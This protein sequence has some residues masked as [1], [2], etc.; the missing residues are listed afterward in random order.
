MRFLFFPALWIQATFFAAWLLPASLLRAQTYDLQSGPTIAFFGDNAVQLGWQKPTGFIHLI[1]L[2][3]RQQ[4]QA[5]TV[6]PLGGGGN[7]SKDLL[8]RLG[9]D[10]LSKKPNFLVLNCGVSDV[11]RGPKNIPLDQYQASITAM[12]DQATAAG[13]KV[14][15]LTSTMI[16]EDAANPKNQIL[17]PYNDFLRTLAKQKNIPLGDV[18]AAMQAAVAQARTET[19]LN[20]RMLTVSDTDLNSVGDEIVAAVTLKPLG[21]PDPQ[22]AQARDLWLDLPNGMD[23][24]L[25][26]AISVRQYLLLRALAASQGRS[27]DDLINDTL[28]T[29]LQKMLI[30]A[31]AAVPGGAKH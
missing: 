31:P 15:L 26:P 28:T 17:A 13:V 12:V 24:T 4:G 5:I 20:G 22:I 1:D 14:V 30:K 9:R 11:S 10:A 3:Y 29:E 16:T 21:F 7:T 27:V 23:V 8:G 19:H 6:F 18:N 25:H 2:A